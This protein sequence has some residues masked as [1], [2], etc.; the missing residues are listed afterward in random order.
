MID[1]RVPWFYGWMG[2]RISELADWH[3][4]RGSD[5]QAIYEAAYLVAMFENT[6]N[7]IADALDLR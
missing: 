6:W 3:E 2:E 7:V 4:E 5:E 1:A